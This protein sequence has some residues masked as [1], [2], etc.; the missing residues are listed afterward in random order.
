[1]NELKA[2]LFDLDGTMLDNNGYHWLSLQE[3]LGRLGM[4]L[5]NEDYKANISGRTNHDATEHIFDKKM[6]KKEAEQYYLEKEKIYREMYAPFISPVAGLLDLLQELQRN[7]VKMAIATSGIQVNI[8]FMFEHVPVKKY[9]NKVINST[10]ISKGK[11]DPEIFIVTADALN[12]NPGDCIVF[13]DSISGVE[14]G[15]AAGM[16][17][18]ALTTTHQKDELLMADLVIHDYTQICI[19]QLKSLINNHAGQATD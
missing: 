16:K 14:A 10:H 17:V 8:D 11:P 9:F 12:L 4:R 1:M 19:N 13:E 2:I 7:K 18:V 15:K 3:Y 6:S 5:S